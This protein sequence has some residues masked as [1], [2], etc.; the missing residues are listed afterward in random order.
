MLAI[1]SESESLWSQGLFS[2]RPLLAAVA[3]TIVLQL[4]VIYTP[5]LHPIFNTQPLSFAEIG[6]CVLL[7]S[8]VLLSVEFEKWLRRHGVIYQ[9]RM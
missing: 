7:A 5:L 2:N 1:R 9:A 6:L 8:T 3:L 4:V